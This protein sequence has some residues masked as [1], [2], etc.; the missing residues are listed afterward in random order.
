MSNQHANVESMR[1]WWVKFQN[2]HVFGNGVETAIAFSKI[3]SLLSM[4][5]AANTQIAELEAEIEENSWKAR[6]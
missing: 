4:L 5:E 2:T 3:N 6:S 1:K